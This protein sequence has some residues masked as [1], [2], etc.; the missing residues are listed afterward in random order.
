MPA[1][2]DAAV[3]DIGAAKILDP[4]R[5]VGERVGCWE[6]DLAVRRAQLR[7]DVGEE[8]VE[9]RPLERARPRER[10]GHPVL[11]RVLV[12]VEGVHVREREVLLVDHPHRELVLRHRA[13]GQDGNEAS[14]LVAGG[15][16]PAHDVVGECL[17]ELGRLVDDLDPEVAVWVGCQLCSRDVPDSL[18]RL[19]VTEA[20]E[21]SEPVCEVRLGQ[22]VSP[23]RAAVAASCLS[24]VSNRGRSPPRMLRRTAA[25]GSGSLSSSVRRYRRRC[26]PSAM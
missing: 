10:R 17:V 24:G 7:L 1:P 6:V 22:W 12:H 2:A 21:A 5:I 25:R 16:D 23:L 4:T 15:A 14:P 8:V 3:A 13:D 11:V 20:D 18:A 19:Q 9:H 26:D